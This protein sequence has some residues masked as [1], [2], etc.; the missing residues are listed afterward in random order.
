M[1][2]Y[3]AVG[4]KKEQPDGAFCVEISGQPLLLSDT[5]SFI[6]TAAV[7]SFTRKEELQGRMEQLLEAVFGE[8]ERKVT[9]EDFSSCFQRLCTRGLLAAGKVL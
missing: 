5:E 7:W 3:T 4:M 9:A 6:W 8:E 1:E 2:Y